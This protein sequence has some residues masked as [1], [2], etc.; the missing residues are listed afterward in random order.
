MNKYAL[1][2]DTSNYTTSVA[3]VDPEGNIISDV[4]KLVNVKQGEKGLRQSYAL[5]QHVESLPILFKEAMEGN[6]GKI[7]A[8]SVSVRPRPLADSYM[9]VFKAGE[10][11]ASVVSS[12]LDVPLY[13]FSH[14]EGH[15]EAV[16][17]YS[18]LKDEDDLL[19]YHLSGG[20][21]E[22]LKV[23]KGN[24]EILGGTKDISFGQVLDRIGV[25]LGMQFPC[26][27]KLDQIALD[28]ACETHFLK[29]ISLDGMWMNLSGIETQALRILQTH[30]AGP[31]T[32]GMIKEI[33]NKIC[34][35]LF[36]IT[37]NAISQT[38]IS[39]VLFSGGVC[40]SRFIRSKLLSDLK[41]IGI[42]AE[43]GSQKLSSDNAVGIALLGGKKLW[44]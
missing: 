22:L 33:F 19:S 18:Q 32:D 26:G 13:T 36:K 41:A 27:D 34:K 6:H 1:G 20:T 8:V 5:F 4:R 21:C 43:F 9:P 17:W 31:E 35:C 11:F 44:L 12:A 15:I 16:K 40:A 7:G 2:I 37:E 14:Q 10:S 39:N 29:D 23:I 25:T 30:C 38:R 3:I 42:K 28:T 24:I